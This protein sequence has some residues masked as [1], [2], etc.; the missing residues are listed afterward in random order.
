[1]DPMQY[2]IDI[3]AWMHVEANS[4][5]QAEEIALNRLSALL[6]TA[7]NTGKLGDWTITDITP[8]DAA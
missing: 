1:M 6:E 7:V 8:E 3:E 2:A 4:A 5:E